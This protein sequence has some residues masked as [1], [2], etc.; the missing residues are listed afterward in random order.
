LSEGAIDRAIQL[1]K[2]QKHEYNEV[3]QLGAEILHIL[4]DLQSSP[5]LIESLQLYLGS[6]IRT[7]PLLHRS[8]NEAR[9]EYTI[10]TVGQLVY[11]WRSTRWDLPDGARAEGLQVETW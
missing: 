7:I 2:Q 10:D 1:K 9:E 4:A 5:N 3:E 6:E 8:L 11:T